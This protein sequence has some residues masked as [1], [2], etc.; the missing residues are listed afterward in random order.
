MINRR[1]FGGAL[2]GIAA[3]GMANNSLAA[4]QEPLK[5]TLMHV[6]GDYHNIVGGDITSKQNL[7]YNLRHGVKHLTAEVS[8]N[9]QGAWD[10]DDLQRMKDNCDKY[11][12]VLEAIRMNS[13]YINLLRKGPE[14]E[15]E[16]EIIAGNIR[17]VSKDRRKNHNLSL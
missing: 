1:E 5:N 9:P 16:I 6:G 17:K 12:V 14:R 11:G 13:H 15:R 3:Q 8:K 2:I 7:E 10:S 4:E